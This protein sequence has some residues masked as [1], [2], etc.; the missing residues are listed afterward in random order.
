MGHRSPGQNGFELSDR[1]A[2]TNMKMWSAI[3]G[4]ERP[5]GVK[6]PL[7]LPIS[8]PDERRTILG[9]VAGDGTRSIWNECFAF[10]EL[11][12]SFLV[13]KEDEDK[14][15]ALGINGVCRAMQAYGCW[16]VVIARS[17][18]SHFGALGE[19]SRR[20]EEQLSVLGQQLDL[21]NSR[22]AELEGSLK[23]TLALP[24]FLL[25]VFDSLPA[26][27]EI[28]YKICLVI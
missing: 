26:Y 27:F 24:V 18:E 5:V 25:T 19:Q 9:P 7:L 2:K 10:P 8:Q 13:A 21:A 3:V 1:E 4:L 6:A 28:V 20:Y 15:E 11:I 22:V 12:N 23:T 14:V 17:A 16:V